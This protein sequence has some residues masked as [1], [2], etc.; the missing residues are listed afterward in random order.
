M[1]TTDDDTPKQ[2]T[3]GEMSRNAT[4]SRTGWELPKNPAEAEAQLAETDARLFEHVVSLAEKDPRFAPLV[5]LARTDPGLAVRISGA[6]VGSAYE[7][8]R[9]ARDYPEHAWIL[10]ECRK[11]IE[12]MVNASR[13]AR[14]SIYMIFTAHD[15]LR[16]EVADAAFAATKT[17]ESERT[18]EARDALANEIATWVHG[19]LEA[20]GFG[21]GFRMS[22]P[23]EGGLLLH[24]VRFAAELERFDGMKPHVTKLWEAS[25]KRARAYEEGSNS[26]K[27]YELWL[28]PAAIGGAKYLKLLAHALWRNVVQPQRKR[29]A[30]RNPAGIVRVVVHDRLLPAMTKQLE[31]PSIDDG[32]VRDASGKVI[33]R[34]TV[35]T[36]ATLEAA[37]RGLAQLGSVAGHRLVRSL[38][39]RA[40][41][42][43][44]A[45]TGDFRHVRYEGGFAALLETVGLGPN[46][47]ET[48]REIAEAGQAIRWHASHAE[49]GGFWTWTHQR[50]ARGRQGH[51]SFVLGEVLLPGNATAMRIRGNQSAAARMARRII[52]ELRGEVPIPAGL[53]P[54]KHGAAWTLH[55]MMLVELVDHARDLATAGFASIPTSRVT[56]LARSAG[57]T[58][59]DDLARVLDA[60]T[61]GA[62]NVAPIF[63]RDG[64]G[65]T[66][67]DYH[68]RE[69]D[70]I[71]D[72][73]KRQATGQAGGKLA[74]RNRH[75]GSPRRRRSRE[76]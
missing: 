68:A 1:T 23:D 47:G 76:T 70:Y 72:L 53:S 28:D 52:P 63:K 49:G 10:D 55:R 24:D 66:L 32:A 21:E 43:Y 31:I 41:D 22:P 62:G 60:F 20:L 40:H 6:A 26:G 30:E 36:D 42:Q 5:L 12:P 34:I 48:I 18:N 50:G 56:E 15:L 51:V 37:R 38:V 8:R 17:P 16:S 29:D 73:G 25:G 2:K 57:L 39:H 58:R 64:D 65:W 19:H 7:A 54:D 4:W 14:S 13:W 27:L 69:R 11:A 45:G 33:G 46:Y 71:A 67:A 75:E 61:N 3:I 59:P 9:I 35:T 74:A 44:E